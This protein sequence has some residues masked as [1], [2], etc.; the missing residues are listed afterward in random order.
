[1]DRKAFL[2]SIVVAG[3]L[4]VSTL[5][6]GCASSAQTLHVA[7]MDNRVVLPLANV[8]GL[9]E[10]DA[11]AKLYVDQYANPIILF[12]QNGV[13]RAVLSTCSHSGCEVR[14]L[15][16]K[17]E[18]PCHGSQYDL[19]GA[20]LKGPASEPLDTFEVKWDGDRLEFTL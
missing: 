13:P 9:D 18:C 17:F 6:E 15:K 12:M 10:P 7:S 19:Q 8:P 5:L 2:Q 14:K 16:A 20:V 11:Y 4:P 1:M 3:C